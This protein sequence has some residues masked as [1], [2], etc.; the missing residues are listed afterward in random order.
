[1]PKVSAWYNNETMKYFCHGD[2]DR[3]TGNQGDDDS[4]RVSN[5]MAVAQ[6]IEY[7]NSNLVSK[8]WLKEEVA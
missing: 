6:L 5:A 8:Y 4:A 7:A 2:S 3:K 1:M